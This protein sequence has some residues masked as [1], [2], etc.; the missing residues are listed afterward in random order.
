MAVNLRSDAESEQ[1]ALAVKYI[2][3]NETLKHLYAA[4]FP[5][6]F[7]VL[8][9]NQGETRRISVLH[10][11]SLELN[12]ITSSPVTNYNAE[13]INLHSLESSRHCIR[14]RSD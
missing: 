11:R 8:G 2:T 9:D 12:S 10:Q 7:R 14:P 6:Q 5:T 4:S 3:L 1:A 13:P